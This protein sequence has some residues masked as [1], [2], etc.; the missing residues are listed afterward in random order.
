[1]RKTSLLPGLLTFAIAAVI[2]VFAASLAVSQIEDRSTASVE[3]ALRDAGLDWVNAGSD[4]L[5]LSLTGTAPDEAARFRALSVAGKVVDAGRVDDL[6][7][8]S[9]TTPIAAPEFS[10]EILRQSDEITMIG[11]IPLAS[12]RQS[13]ADRVGRSAFEVPIVDLLE[14][15]DFPA[16]AGWSQAVDYALAALKDLER[17]KVSIRADLVSITTA[18]ESTTERERLARRLRSAAPDGLRIS[19]DIGAPRPVVSP[20]ILRVVKTPER[21]RFDACSAATETGA[22]L[23][24]AAARRIG[25]PESEDCRL[26]LGVPSTAWAD[27]ASA[28]IAVLADLDAGR[29]TLSDLSLTIEAGEGQD[30]EVFQAAIADLRKELPTEFTLTA[31]LP[32]DSALAPELGPA[33]FT[34]TRSPEGLVQLRGRL[35]TERSREVVIAFAR[36]LFG[37]E[38]V[39]PSLDVAPQVPQGWGPRVL[40]A[41][42]A[43]SI[44]TNGA[45][46][47]TED[48][49]TVTGSS[50]AQEADDEVARILSAQLGDGA[51]YD[52]DITY[53]KRADP[54]LALP[55][56][57]ECVE[58]ANAILTERQITFDPGSATIDSESRSS[59]DA[60]AEIVRKCEGVAMEVGGFTDSQG[61]ETMNQQLSQQ[62]AEALLAALQV[63]RV[64]ITDLTAVGYG[65]ANPIASN[66]TADGREANRRLEFRLLGGQDTA[67]DDHGHDEGSGDAE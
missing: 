58:Q 43:L 53:D 45:V 62:R 49:I 51:Q 39:N 52:I 44:L 34:V 56:P 60:I 41:L 18:A 29:V 15:A 48:N 67:E 55:S 28:A 32:D 25:V 22:R 63:Q 13:L 35:A 38:K 50:G 21:T 3:R 30:P 59:V 47:V 19:L 61:R 17:A 40:V 33:E 57:E 14:T 65:E 7:D 6:M 24:V 11:L 26:A 27:T 8:V 46:V 66:D 64:L 1:M 2:S 31:I 36:S 9:K 12:D 5:R 23:I 20:F 37:V 54:T 16:P 10:I 4:G 42:D